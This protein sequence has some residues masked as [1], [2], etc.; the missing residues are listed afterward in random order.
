MA[1]QLC[2][3]PLRAANPHYEGARYE[4][5]LSQQHIRLCL[6]SPFTD[7]LLCSYVMDVC[8]HD[9]SRFL[10]CV[11]SLIVRQL[12]TKSDRPKLVGIA[13]S[14]AQTSP[15]TLTDRSPSP[16]IVDFIMK[17]EAIRSI[18]G[19]AP[20]RNLNIFYA[21][22]GD[23]TFTRTHLT[24]WWSI[25]S[26]EIHWAP[27]VRIFKASSGRDTDVPTRQEQS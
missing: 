5:S 6:L 17:F 9:K 22:L 27:Q 21:L 7:T 4:T 14:S 26:T 15:D 10:A 1:C 12:T 3:G 24:S 23:L 20:L 18:C 16:I 11:A 19:R 25:R 8:A 13:A 2:R